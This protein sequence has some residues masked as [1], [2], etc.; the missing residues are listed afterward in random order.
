MRSLSPDLSVKV[1]GALVAAFT[2]AFGVLQYLNTQQIEASKPFLQQK[3]KWCEEAT[4][5]AAAIAVSVQPGK[6]DQFWQMYWGV[7]GMVENE[8][9]TDAMIAF[10]KALKSD[11]D[12][13]TLSQLALGIAHKCRDEMANDWSSIWRRL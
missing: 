10:G 6:K 3:L 5:T 7:M 13:A 12:Q 11:A 2:L 9:V 8:N 1:M 4:E